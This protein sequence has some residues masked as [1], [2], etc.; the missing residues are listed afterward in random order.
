M[1]R[2][3]S[4][5]TGWAFLTRAGEL[6]AVVC[7]SF[8]T[9]LAT[10]LDVSVQQRIESLLLLGLLPAVGFYAGGRALCHL[11]MIG[12]QRRREYV[13][14]LVGQ[15]YRYA[16]ITLAK[17]AMLGQK[18]YGLALFC[19]P[20]VR[21]SILEVSCLLIRSTAQLLLRIQGQAGLYGHEAAT[22]LRHRREQ[23]SD[24]ALCGSDIRGTPL[25][26]YCHGMSA[27]R[28]DQ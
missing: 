15:A 28:C 23:T 14:W 25:V 18:T 4:T 1:S 7:L 24:M 17:L 20:H 27:A 10:I 13:A 2:F 21:R 16:S 9:A 26:Q 11:T 22:P 19:Y 12:K 5:Q 3:R 8:G 6:C